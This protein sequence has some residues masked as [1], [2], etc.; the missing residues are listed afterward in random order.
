[1]KVYLSLPISG[2]EEQERWQ[3]AARTSA[4]LTIAHEDWEVIN[5]FHVASR[6]EK[7]KM[8]EAG[9]IVKPTYEEYMSADLQALSECELALFC[10]GWHGSTGC[11]REMKECWS[12]GIDVAFLSE[13]G[14]VF[15]Q[16]KKDGI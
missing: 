1:M 5:P 11:R 9:H 14:K 4:L 15:G 6:L 7:Q 13:D 8:D 3:Y 2:Y 16:I 12:K 10:P